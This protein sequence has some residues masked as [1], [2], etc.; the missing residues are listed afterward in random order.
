DISGRLVE[1]KIIDSSKWSY[2]PAYQK[3]I[4]L[5]KLQG[6]TNSLKIRI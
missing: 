2:K 4:Y 6:R 3:G 5:I 1:S